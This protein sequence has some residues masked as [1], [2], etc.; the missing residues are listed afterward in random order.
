MTTQAE[1]KIHT[2]SGKKGRETI[3]L[4]PVPREETQSKREITH[5]EVLPE[6]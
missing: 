2:E 4:G 1:R 6:E 5:A 3:R